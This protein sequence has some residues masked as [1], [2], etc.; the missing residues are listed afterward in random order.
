[1]SELLK[2]ITIKDNVCNG[3]PTIR[4]Y[5]LT[6][7]TVLEFLLAGTGEKEL[8]KEYPFLEEND[9]KACKEFASLIMNNKYSLTDLAA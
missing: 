4:G 5:R 2:R 3:R 6:V 9:I 8:L 1:M 7:Q